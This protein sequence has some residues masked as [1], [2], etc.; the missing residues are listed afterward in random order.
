MLLLLRKGVYPYDYVDSPDK[1][2]ET[3]LPPLFT[4]DNILTGE[5]ITEEDYT[6]AKQV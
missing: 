5:F 2:Q 4:S 3:Q 1:L 6:Y